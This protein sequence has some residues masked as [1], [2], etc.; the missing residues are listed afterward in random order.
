MAPPLDATTPES[1]AKDV[2]L[3]TGSPRSLEVQ[4]AENDETILAAKA[5]GFRKLM[6]HIGGFYSA[7]S[8]SMR[9]ANLLYQ[10]CTAAADSASVHT[11]LDLPHDFRAKHALLCLHVW[12]FLVRLR[13][14]GED[15]K[16][17]GQAMYDS[18]QEDVEMRVRAEGVTVRVSKW[19]KELESAFYGSCV[20]YDKAAAGEKGELTEALWRNV[21]NKE[22]D[23]SKAADLSLHVRQLLASLSM[24]STDA[25][26][27]G[28][29]SVREQ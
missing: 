18:F 3:F 25:M 28:L 6:L 26:L 13:Q 24:T 23:R 1:T 16:R 17:L 11:S 27:K 14:E 4:P 2:Q 5:T 7:E 8:A 10:E 22:G 19:L 29:V 12:L 21:Y 20:A 9:A 15:G